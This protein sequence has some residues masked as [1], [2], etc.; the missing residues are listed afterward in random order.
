MDRWPS[1]GMFLARVGQFLALV[2]QEPQQNQ[3]IGSKC[4]QLN[5][6]SEAVKTL[7]RGFP[8]SRSSNK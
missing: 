6:V 8:L 1:E 4:P 3:S 7:F 5:T 2:K